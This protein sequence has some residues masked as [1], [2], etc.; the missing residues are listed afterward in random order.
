MLLDLTLGI[1]AQPQAYKQYRGG[2]ALK[3]P[4]LKALAAA[5]ICEVDRAIVIAN[6]PAK[7]NIALEP[8]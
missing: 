3:A 4:S 1:T 6:G 7:A 8:S 2:T 5:A